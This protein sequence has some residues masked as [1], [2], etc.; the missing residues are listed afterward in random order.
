MI[1]CRHWSPHPIKPSTGQCAIDAHHEPSSGV[2]LKTCRQYE[3]PPRPI[4]IMVSARPPVTAAKV[5][6]FAVAV[7]TGKFVDQATIDQRLA[8]CATCVHRKTDAQGASFCN[9]CGCSLSP[10]AKRITNLAAY[11]ENLPAWG[12]KH[13]RREQGEGW[14]LPGSGASIPEASRPIEP[15]PIEPR[16]TP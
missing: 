16:V 4:P 1:E 13:P 7:I 9:L 8:I 15:P 14:P 2:C 11:E 6:T 12:C 3:G 5:A 10:K